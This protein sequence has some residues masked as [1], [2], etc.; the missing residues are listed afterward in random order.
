MHNHAKHLS[1]LFFGLSIGLMLGGVALNPSSSRASERLNLT[2]GTYT[3][4][5]S[6][7]S[8]QV[9]VS[10]KLN[11]VHPDTLTMIYTAYDVNNVRILSSTKTTPQLN[12]GDTFQDTVV[13][14]EGATPVS[15]Y[16]EAQG[17]S[18]GADV[19]QEEQ[20]SNF[21]CPQPHA[22]AAGP[23]P[24]NI[25]TPTGIDSYTVRVGAI[26]TQQ[27]N[28]LQL[29]FTS[30]TS[31]ITVSP[32][33]ATLSL[34]PDVPWATNV[35]VQL[36]HATAPIWFYV[37][38]HAD[39]THQ[40]QYQLGRPP[41]SDDFPPPPSAPTLTLSAATY[42]FGKAT[43]PIANQ[44]TLVGLDSQHQN[45]PHH[46]M[47]VYFSAHDQGGNDYQ[48]IPAVQ[49]NLNYTPPQGGATFGTWDGPASV[50]VRVNG[51]VQGPH[52]GPMNGPIIFTAILALYDNGANQ[53]PTFILVPSTKT[54]GGL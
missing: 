21:T 53:P 28:N 6:G 10:V 49:T 44:I 47:K 50:S 30:P 7:V 8:D 52:I 41:L 27:Q 34:A 32:P 43:V 35:T 22:A 11:W 15:F 45:Q 25:G 4:Y 26:S 51:P 17:V 24:F 16:A 23:G 19:M 46:N 2:L 54:F 48:C 14:P 13:V 42:H 18:G 3:V 33:N 12:N 40:L 31:G 20:I 37:A 38:N 9:P 29:D 39:P 5:Q 1:R 36:G